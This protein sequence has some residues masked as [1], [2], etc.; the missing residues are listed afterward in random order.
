MSTVYSWDELTPEAMTNLFL[1]GQVTRPEQLVDAARVRDADPLPVQIDMAS[2]MDDGPGRF[3]NAAMSTLVSRF[4]T[5]NSELLAG[6]GVGDR[7]IGV[8]DMIGMIGGSERFS[9]QQYN[10]DDGGNESGSKNVYL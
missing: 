3:A 10:Y 1:Y 9:Y 8:Q 2:F 6:N 7:V 5:S 4:F